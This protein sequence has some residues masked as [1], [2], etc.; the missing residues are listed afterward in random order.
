MGA[1]RASSIL[2][3]MRR[4]RSLLLALGALLS[5]ACNDAH[6]GVTAPGGNSARL[7]LGATALLAT[8]ATVVVRLSYPRKDGT[9]IELGTK[10]TTVSPGGTTPTQTL[11]L[12]VDIAGCLGDANK[13][14]P[15]GGVVGTCP[16]TVSIQL[17][18]GTTVLDAQSRTVNLTA[19]QTLSLPDP[20]SLYEVTQVKMTLG[21]PVIAGT[22]AKAELGQRVTATA[23]V[24]DRT[25]AD[26]AGRTV[27]W[28]TSTPTVLKLSATTG[29][30]INVDVVGVGP[31][32][33]TASSGERSIV[34]PLDGAPESAR[35]VVVQPA[36]STVF[37]GDTVRYSAEA[38][39]VSGA[40]VA[41]STFTYSSASTAITISMAGVT[42]ARALGTAT[43]VATT[44]S[45]P[46]GVPVTGT[47]TLI[48]V[49]RPALIV[50]PTSLDLSA[51][52][53]TTVP[54]SPVV[55]TVSTNTSVT[56]ITA[57]TAYTTG[58][59]TG[60]ITTTL[61]KTT[62]P[63][64]LGVQLTTQSLLPGV[65]TANI[66]LAAGPGVT[67]VILPVRFTVRSAVQLTATPTTID[68]GTLD[69]G[70][71]AA[72]QIV[73][74][75]TRDGRVAS[76]LTAFVTLGTNTTVQWLGATLATVSTNT[77][78]RLLPVTG[79]R[80]GTYT[81]TVTVQATT[82]TSAQPVS[83]PV[84]FRVVAQRPT[85]TLQGRVY[86]YVT[87]AGIAGASLSI[88]DSL[89]QGATVL[90]DA[91]G[92]FNTTALSGGPFTISVTATGY[93]SVTVR[94]VVV[95]GARILDA[96]PMVPV[97]TGNG[98]I[99]G[100]V[101]DAT[102]NAAIQTTAT[103]QLFSGQNTI[104]G[105]PIATVF[106]ATDG[107][108]TYSNVPPGT[109]TIV[110]KASGFS[111]GSRTGVSVGGGQ[112]TPRQ[113]L[114]LSPTGSAILLRVVLSWG[115]LPS[116]LD[117]YLSGPNGVGGTFTINYSNRGSCSA[118]PFACL[119]VDVTTGYGPET[120]AVTRLTGGQRYVYQVHNFT[121]DGLPNSST[122]ARSSARVD[123]FSATGLI[124]SFAVPSGVG[125]LWSVFDWDGTT[126][127]PI[128]TISNNPPPLPAITAG[129]IMV[130][131]V[132]T[133]KTPTPP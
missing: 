101:R 44:T 125:T 18:R 84:V 99:T 30:S 49:P 13:V 60:W 32:T 42:V 20:I 68:F 76:G 41:G 86:D 85:G 59:P 1:E 95:S 112:I 38:R 79:L 48:V 78:L 109:Y 9:S 26:V 100:I 102:R 37:L 58:Q 92:N 91:S 15:T 83:I 114:F 93:T 23:N 122:L 131:P 27:T 107:S 123:V 4:G 24:L 106:S 10:S 62:V 126:I 94:N 115:A 51:D 16:A 72:A 21:G 2:H 54:L 5:V 69:S 77:T 14:V 80:S 11:S 63:A 89:R 25:G 119:D 73:N 65:Y 3:G 113:D 36:D 70:V 55:V 40:V 35:T 29:A 103:V 33:I 105:T 47:T 71:V 90:T 57:T 28:S 7:Q 53:A 67:G 124:Q 8:D 12:T 19:G 17:T 82:P 56:G 61:D 104:S 34:V 118:L 128:N 117:S 130:G 120:I 75:S 66:T 50:N 31:G 127:R 46:G 129:S 121:D 6:K 22:P 133:K 97:T 45:G 111:D 96:V 132:R 116:D 81:A 64:T 98:I 87:N 43:I 108:Y 110:A 88:R 39:G 52:S 74:I